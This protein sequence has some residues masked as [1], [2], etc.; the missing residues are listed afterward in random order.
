MLDVDMAHYYQSTK[1]AN[2]NNINY[3]QRNPSI[4]TYPTTNR[5]IDKPNFVICSSCLW[6]ASCMNL[7]KLIIRCPL[8]HDNKIRCIS[9]SSGEHIYYK[10]QERNNNGT[11][12]TKIVST[13]L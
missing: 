7:D 3:R 6:C 4:N 10:P 8:C 2:Q 1:N 12:A 9:I 11:S 5:R 13:L